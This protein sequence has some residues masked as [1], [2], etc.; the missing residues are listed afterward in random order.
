MEKKIP[1]ILY[2]NNYISEELMRERNNGNVYSQAGNNKV[3]GIFKSLTYAGAEVKVISCGLVSGRECKFFGKKIEMTEIGEI[4]YASAF[5][6]P[7]LNIFVSMFS[8]WHEIKRCCGI[9]KPDCILFYNFKVETAIPAYWASKKYGV[10]ISVEYEDGY[11]SG[12]EIGRFKQKVL[13][14]VEENIKPYLTSAILVTTKVREKFNI[15]N[16]V[17]RGIIN[18]EYLEFCKNYNKK[19]HE[20]MLV[21][22]S[23]GLEEVRGIKV[24]LDAVKYCKADFKLVIIG[25][26]N[27]KI[28]DERIEYKGFLAYDEVKEYM[29]EADV[30]IQCQLAKHDFGEVSFPSKIF[31]YLATGNYIISS[32]VS[33]MKEFSTGKFVIYEDDSPVELAMEIDKA[34]L[35][36]KEGKISENQLEELCVSNS[37]QKLGENI[38]EVL[39]S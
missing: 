16:I 19:R 30:L 33:D 7:I 3:L 32:D 27:I 36:W 28:E 29:A 13:R 1:Q 12:G 37:P 9:Q 2:I 14:L 4:F 24:L 39:L 34:Y 38:L 10:P 11:G 15:P 8:V 21:L 17:V 25:K 20:K 26:G 31:E 22:Y 23:G 35:L 6:F 18:E 5:S